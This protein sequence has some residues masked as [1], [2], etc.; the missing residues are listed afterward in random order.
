M[1]QSIPSSNI[2]SCAGL[3]ATRPMLVVGQR[4]WPFSSLLLNRHR[5]GHQTKG[6]GSIK[7]YNAVVM[8]PQAM[9]GILRQI[10]IE[11]WALSTGISQSAL[12]Q[13]AREISDIFM[14]SQRVE[15]N[16]DLAPA[17]IIELVLG[18]DAKNSIKQSKIPPDVLF[19]GVK[20]W[21]TLN[22]RSFTRS[23][24]QK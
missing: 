22:Q 12:E 4:K 11:P 16:F 13:T 10:Y 3:S 21:Q 15:Q 5:L 20:E 18:T 6:N 2:D 24:K 9:T 1:R 8:S 14:G 23:T 19:M 7:D 17:V